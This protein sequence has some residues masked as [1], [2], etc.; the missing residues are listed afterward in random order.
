MAGQV[1]GGPTR[2]AAAGSDALVEGDQDLRL[3]NRGLRDHQGHHAGA[4]W[5]A[6][7]A[8]GGVCGPGR[9]VRPKV[10]IDV[11]ADLNMEDD[12]GRNLARVP[13]GYSFAP[14]D[15]AMAGRQQGWSWVLL[16]LS[17]I[18]I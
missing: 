14:G 15:V 2:Y 17:L 6:R 7:A 18:H 16:D 10:A 8:L 13:R 11:E 5:V 12:E 9:R 4:G 1:D 3:T